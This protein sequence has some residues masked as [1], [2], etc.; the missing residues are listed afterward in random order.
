MRKPLTDK[1]HSGLISRCG[2][3]TSAE[4][5]VLTPHPYQPP[6]LGAAMV[7]LFGEG[8]VL[9]CLQHLSPWRVAARPAL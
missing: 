7:P 8:F 4:A 9:R 1:T 5:L 3:N 6:L 2:L